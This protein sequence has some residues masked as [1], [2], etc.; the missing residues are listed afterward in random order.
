MI[1]SVRFSSQR[2]KLHLIEKRQ[3]EN[4]VKEARK[5]K[6]EVDAE[7]KSIENENVRLQDQIQ[8]LNDRASVLEAAK[9]QL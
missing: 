3:K 6:N 9:L 2:R 1:E 7:L 5:R 8:E 4:E